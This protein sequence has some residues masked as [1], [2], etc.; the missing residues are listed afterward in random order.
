MK[1][2]QFESYDI[3]APFTIASNEPMFDTD[4]ISL[5]KQR[6]SQGVQRWELSFNIITSSPSSLMSS[7][8]DFD[9]V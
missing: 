5:K 6:S 1:K 2:Y 9:D 3:V 4:S 7:I 8:I